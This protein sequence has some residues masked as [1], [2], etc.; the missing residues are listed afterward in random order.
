[1]NEKF[2]PLSVP[3][4][5]GNELKYVSNCIET[6]WVSTAGEYVDRFEKEFARYVGSK[7]AVACSNGTAALHISLILAGVSSEDEVIIPTVTFI[8]PVNTIRYIDASPIFMDCDEYLNIDVEN[9]KIFCEE[10]CHFNGTYLIN[11]KS[12]KKVKA[13]IPVH[14][15]GHPVR[16]DELMKLS[17]KYNLKIIED[18][19]ESLG[20]YYTK[21]D[22]KDK[23]TG[24]IGD[25][26]C[27]SFNGN[28]IITTGGG[29]MLVT[30][31]KEFAEKAK[32]L[33]TQAKDDPVYYVHNEVGYNY[34]MT[35]LQAALGVA[36][37]EKIEKYIEIKRK[38]FILY[39]EAIDNI[40]GLSLI[41]EPE[42]AFSNFWMYSLVVEEE[43]YG[44]NRDELLKALS[45][46]KIQTRPLW[47]LNHTQK[48][49]EIFEALDMENSEKTYKKILNIPCSVNIREEDITRITGVLK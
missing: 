46:A 27:F 45:E 32:Y 37:L 18:S 11:K 43:K 19:T 21:G 16:I 6:E 47:K 39:K 49:F 44:K 8:A 13:I 28:K 17:K 1:V 48:P 33:T 38:N 29:G 22:F 2:I 7:Y 31:N 12:G 9:T 10:E 24:T 36:Q 3:S 42:Y 35:N 25:L 40:E 4:F 41:D 23:K 30:D 5:Q 20:S 26:G 14:I 15:F 34:R